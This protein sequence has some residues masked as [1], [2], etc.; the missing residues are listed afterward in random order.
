MYILLSFLIATLFADMGYGQERVADRISMLFFINAFLVFMS[1]A[2]IPACT[3]RT[4]RSI[5][6]C[7]SLS[8]DRC[9]LY[10]LCE[11]CM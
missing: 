11:P 8:S 9:T 6:H 3:L 2:V 7:I 1:I 4:T 5:M 10:R